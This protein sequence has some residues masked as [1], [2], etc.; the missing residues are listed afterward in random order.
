MTSLETPM[1][2]S[3]KVDGMEMDSVTKIDVESKVNHVQIMELK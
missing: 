3:L 1:N 2:T